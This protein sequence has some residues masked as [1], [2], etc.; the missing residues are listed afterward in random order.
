[1]TEES[2]RAS[3]ARVQLGV[4]FDLLRWVWELRT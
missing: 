2:G 1:M 3:D 4:N